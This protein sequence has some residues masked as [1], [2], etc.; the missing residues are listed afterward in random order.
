MYSVGLAGRGQRHGREARQSGPVNPVRRQPKHWH[1]VAY[2]FTLAYD[3]LPRV[4]DFRY[5]NGKFRAGVRLNT[6]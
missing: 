4:A 6:G 2:V 5:W 1:V 3:E